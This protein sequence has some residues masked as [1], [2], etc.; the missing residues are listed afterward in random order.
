[1]KKK[2]KGDKDEGYGNR[3]CIDFWPVR[4]YVLN[5]NRDIDLRGW[6]EGEETFSFEGV[7]VFTFLVL[8]KTSLHFI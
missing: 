7:L 4:V 1:M 6:F 2:K 8:L 5:K 3:G